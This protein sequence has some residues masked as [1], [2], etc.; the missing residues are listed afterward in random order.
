MLD[1]HRA[2]IG[3]N[4]SGRGRGGSGWQ[5]RTFCQNLQRVSSKQRQIFVAGPKSAAICS[6]FISIV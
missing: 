1:I 6:R 3:R 2:F 5:F 4:I